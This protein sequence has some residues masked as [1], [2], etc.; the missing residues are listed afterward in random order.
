MARDR[1]SYVLMMRH[2]LAMRAF[3]KV[4]IFALI[5]LAFSMRAHADS[6]NDLLLPGPVIQGHVKYESDCANCHNSSPP[7]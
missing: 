6:V 5:V 2:I 1:G 4:F 3:T 7:F